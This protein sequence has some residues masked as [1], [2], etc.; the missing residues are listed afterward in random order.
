MRCNR[1]V[2]LLNAA[3]IRKRIWNFWQWKRTIKQDGPAILCIL[4]S[5]GHADAML[6]SLNG[7]VLYRLWART[8]VPVND[9]LWLLLHRLLIISTRHTLAPNQ[10]L[11]LLCVGGVCRGLGIVR[12]GLVV[13]LLIVDR[14]GLMI[15][16]LHI[17][18]LLLGWLLLNRGR[19]LVRYR[20]WGPIRR[21]G[22][23]WDVRVLPSDVHAAVA[24][25]RAESPL[26]SCALRILWWS[27]IWRRLGGRLIVLRGLGLV[28][29]GH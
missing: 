27:G 5:R 23:C 24:L 13:V 9:L 3:G 21:L 18:W 25:T 22:L 17:V 1:T 4:A 29:T 6:L 14:R 20:W 8:P 16:W 2:L 10:S 11:W 26:E 15:G 19:L 7:L 28:D 12:L